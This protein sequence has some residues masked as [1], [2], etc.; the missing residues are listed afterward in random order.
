MKNF[1]HMQNNKFHI[2]F[3][4]PSTWNYFEIC[5]IFGQKNLIDIFKSF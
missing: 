2:M 4:Q 3:E 5:C 1:F